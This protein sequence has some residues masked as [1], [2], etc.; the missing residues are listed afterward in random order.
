MEPS[1]KGELK[2]CS[3]GQVPLIKLAAMPKI[4]NDSK[5]NKNFT[6]MKY[7]ET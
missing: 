5:K 2:I 6:L 4:S 7:E 1:V 3:N